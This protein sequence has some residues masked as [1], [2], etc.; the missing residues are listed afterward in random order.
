LGGT[1]GVSVPRSDRVHGCLRVRSMVYT[2]VKRSY[3]NPLHICQLTWPS[4]PQP[5]PDA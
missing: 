1:V 3:H 2:D 5:I 4:R